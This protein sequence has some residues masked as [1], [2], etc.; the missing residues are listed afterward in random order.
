[1]S[2]FY[3]EQTQPCFFKINTLIGSLERVSTSLGG[4]KMQG[5]MA[6]VGLIAPAICLFVCFE[7]YGFQP[8]G[9]PFPGGD[10]GIID[11]PRNPEHAGI[12]VQPSPM[13]SPGRPAE[14]PRKPGELPIP[15]QKMTEA[16]AVFSDNHLNEKL[17]GDWIEQAIEGLELIGQLSL[18]GQLLVVTP[19]ELHQSWVTRLGRG[20]NKVLIELGSI[21][22]EHGVGVAVI[23]G[24][25]AAVLYFKS[26][27]LLSSALL[28]NL[29]ALGRANPQFNVFAVGGSLLSGVLLPQSTSSADDS[30]L[31]VIVTEY[32]AE[33]R[34][35]RGDVGFQYLV[36]LAE[37]FVGQDESGRIK[38]LNDLDE[39][40]MRS[41]FDFDQLIR[42]AIF[43]NCQQQA[44]TSGSS[45]I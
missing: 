17:P 5:L 20:L 34:A 8:G 28:Q 45:C 18:T 44:Q 19:E 9:V 1:M 32:A 12:P 23:T 15:I 22:E 13:P 33:E 14:G 3:S 30:R 29:T 43:E 40:V 10:Q 21:S 38:T 4:K 37:D 25:S 6:K 26:R 2:S 36:D 27:A 7:S 41:L 39:S 24:I 35:R 11:P 31:Q 16:D 42:L